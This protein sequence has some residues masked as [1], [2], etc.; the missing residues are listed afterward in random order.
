MNDLNI[1]KE[2]FF[3]YG[4][5][6]IRN[7]LEPLEIEKYRMSIQ[8]ISKEVNAKVVIGIHKY[9]EFWDI[10]AHEKI[11]STIK[12]LLG[13]EEIRYLY[14]AA[15]RHEPPNSWPYSWHRD[16]TCRV[17]G[18]GPDWDKNQIFNVVRVGIY[19]TPY[20]NVRSGINVIPFSHT[21]T[22]TL[23]NLLR[24]FHHKTKN[25]NNFFI[26]MIRNGFEKNTPCNGCKI[27]LD[28]T[29]N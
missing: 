16:N 2:D 15:T 17:F 1:N 23:S 3:K 7:V 18:V 11:L 20:E 4:Y 6:V 8:K 14:N 25:S 22:Y 29:A 26:K 19:L 24:V 13:S 21:K 9:K 5:C 28:N 12:N 27:C 10:I